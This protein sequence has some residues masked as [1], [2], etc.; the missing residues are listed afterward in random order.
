M[1]LMSQFRLNMPSLEQTAVFR[2]MRYYD[3]QSLKYIP[4][5]EN[6][7]PIPGNGELNWSPHQNQ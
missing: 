7:A 6:I 4:I 5:P 1:T 2:I 3:E